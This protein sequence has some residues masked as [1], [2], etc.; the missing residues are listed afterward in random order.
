MKD[1]TS[2]EAIVLGRKRSREETQMEIVKQMLLLLLCFPCHGMGTTVGSGK[3]KSSGTFDVKDF[4][5]KANGMS[6]DSKVLV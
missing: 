4:G 5:A 1:Q 3:D 2:R 6:D